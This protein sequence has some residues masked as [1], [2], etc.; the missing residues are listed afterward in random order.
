M[1]RLERLVAARLGQTWEE[2]PR[3]TFALRRREVRVHW[4]LPIEVAVDLEEAVEAIRQR[5]Q[6]YLPV[7]VALVQLFE[8]V[9]AVWIE[10]DPE[11]EPVWRRILERDD[12][13]CATPGCTR[14]GSLVVHHIRFRSH[15]G[16]SRAWNL[17]TL[18]H[19]CHAHL[20]HE[21]R[22]RV[23]GRAPGRLRWEVGC[24]QGRR[25]LLVLMGER[26]VARR[27]GHG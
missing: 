9:A 3:Q 6:G 8:P 16:C 7:W 20:V 26:I 19:T 27:A 5:R 10:H 1:R 25:A 21:R 24:V 11:S 12:Y 23:R 18:C 22:V 4:V 13:R 14:R 2:A 17:V 15:G